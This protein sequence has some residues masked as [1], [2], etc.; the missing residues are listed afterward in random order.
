[1]DDLFLF[2]IATREI[3]SSWYPSSPSNSQFSADS[4]VTYFTVGGG[5]SFN[6]SFRQFLVKWLFHGSNNTWEWTWHLAACP[7]MKQGSASQIDWQNQSYYSCPHSSVE[8]LLFSPQLVS[9]A[10]LLSG[11]FFGWDTSWS[12]NN[13]MSFRG[14]GLQTWTKAAM[15]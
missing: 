14:I 3:S 12:A 5:G 15:L 11:R 1:M 8:Q 6:I 10:S 9:I 4:S 13:V 2:T 7:M